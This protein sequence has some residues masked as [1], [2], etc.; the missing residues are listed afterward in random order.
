M[1]DNFTSLANILVFCLLTITTI[2]GQVTFS[3]KVVAQSLQGN[4]VIHVDI[5]EDGDE[6]LLVIFPF[7]YL[8]TNDG[9]GQFTGQNILNLDGVRL[10]K[11][12][13]VDLS[14]I[15]I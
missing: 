7:L 12:Y 1:S 10:A 11:P 14:L 6:D 5:D 8:L 9:T 2:Q 3:E 13:D 15:H 4:N